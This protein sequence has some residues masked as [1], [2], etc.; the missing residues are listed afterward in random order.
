MEVLYPRRVI[1]NNWSTPTDPNGS[2][3]NTTR[4]QVR[5]DGMTHREFIEVSK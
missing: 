3:V 5:R 1:D 4:S 2:R